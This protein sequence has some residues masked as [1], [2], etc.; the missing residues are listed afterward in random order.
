MFQWFPMI[1]PL[2]LALLALAAPREVSRSSLSSFF[3][4][5][6][7]YLDPLCVGGRI[8]WVSG[9]QLS[10]RGYKSAKYHWF[11][12]CRSKDYRW[13]CSGWGPL[14][15]KVPSLA[16]NVLVRW[17]CVGWHDNCQWATDRLLYTLN[18]VYIYL[19]FERHYLVLF[20]EALTLHFLDLLTLSNCVRC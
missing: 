7:H 3:V 9:H 5:L 16:P 10:T 19:Y 1:Y 14:T 4:F 18:P 2:A 6:L 11:W 8:C 12:Q 13:V 17:L 15:G 20:L